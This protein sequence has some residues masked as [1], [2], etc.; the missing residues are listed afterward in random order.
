MNKQEEYAGRQMIMIMSQNNQGALRAIME[1]I[2]AKK[3]DILEYCAKNQIF[4]TN[5]YI[6]F[7][8]ICNN[9]LDYMSYLIKNAVETEV[10]KYSHKQDYSGKH[11]FAPMLE[12]Y[13]RS[14][15]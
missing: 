6:L 5:L 3:D 8:D 1:M 10:I 7:N 13:K 9:N 12:D 11:H 4:G 15:L 2:K 14:I